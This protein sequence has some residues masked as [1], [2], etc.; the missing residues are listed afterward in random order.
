MESKLDAKSLDNKSG[1]IYQEFFYGLDPNQTNLS[2]SC[3]VCNCILNIKTNGMNE[4]AKKAVVGKMFEYLMQDMLIRLGVIPFYIQATMANVPLSRFDFL[5]Y[6]P[7]KPV[8]FSVKI[9]LAER[10]R[11]TAFE[12]DSLKRVYGNARC[13]LVTAEKEAAK[14]RNAEIGEGSIIG[15]DKCFVMGEKPLIDKLEELSQETYMEAAQIKPILEY[16]KF[17]RD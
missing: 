17:V 7:R 2:I 4:Q 10:W 13:Y 9:S 1:K 14:K 3:K 5:C 6:H 15:I 16:G 8:V 11:Q 12:G